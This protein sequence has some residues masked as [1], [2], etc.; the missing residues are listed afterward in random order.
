[1][2]LDPIQT[3]NLVEI[4]FNAAGYPQEA[5]SQ[6]QR[7]QAG[8]GFTRSINTDGFGIVVLD[9]I[10]NKNGNLNLIE[11]NGSN[12]A[13][14][15]FG[16]RDGDLA[17]AMHQAE[18]ARE[19]IKKVERGVVLI[20]YAAGTGAMPEIITR[21]ALVRDVISPIRSCYLADTLVGLVDS[22]IT[23]VADTVEKI[24]DHIGVYNG[25]LR[26]AG[27]PVVS[28]GNVNLLPEL[29]RRG[30]VA[31]EGASYAVDTSVFHDGPLVSL[32]HDK[33]AQQ[34]IAAGT[35]IVPLR[36][37]ECND[38]ASCAKAVAEMQALGLACVAKMNGGSGG[39]GIEFFGPTYTSEEVAQGLARVIE[40]ASSKYGDNIGRS[41]WPLRL[42]EFVE[43]TGYPL[44]D[45]D[46]LWDMRIVCLIRPGVIDLTFSSI[47]VCP[48]PFIAG[49]FEKGTVLS[50]V[51]G[52]RPD[53]STTLSPLV[54]FGTPTEHLR[55]GGVDE[56]ILE[57]I[58]DASAKW[59]EA[60]WIYST[61]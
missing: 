3:L 6:V 4:A 36:W 38:M 1:M 28:A 51:T 57:R 23:V 48:E 5:A 32:I 55:A 39:A 15:S 43:S 24:A 12:A 7:P 44:A 53:L 17:R 42:F 25:A 27:V 35:G 8:G 22:A 13:G 61:A 59:C 20:A 52:R 21:A 50:N 54:E 40:A 9:L 37:R 18:A 33:G 58:I 16:S 56:E 34:D 30:V 26:F 46:H 41:V 29:V 10:L 47:R 45:G 14:S 31:R 11:A 19:R 60:A 2:N 49:H